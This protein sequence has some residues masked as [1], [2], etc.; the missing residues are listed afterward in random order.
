MGQECLGP[1]RESTCTLKN[2]SCSIKLLSGH[3]YGG[4]LKAFWMQIYNKIDNWILQITTDEI[5]FTWHKNQQF[6]IPIHTRFQVKKR[7]ILILT[8]ALGWHEEALRNQINWFVLNCN[9]K[10]KHCLKYL[11]LHYKQFF[12]LSVYCGLSIRCLNEHSFNWLAPTV[13]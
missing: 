13:R 7:R 2:S 8:G 12:L 11:S 1:N 5:Y 3:S 9:W 6:S 10:N 4:P